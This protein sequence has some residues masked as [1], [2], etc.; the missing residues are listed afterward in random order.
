MKNPNPDRPKPNL[1]AGCW[2]IPLHRRCPL[3]QDLLWD[4]DWVGKAMEV[5]YHI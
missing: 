2:K 1:A 5:R 4:F 3:L